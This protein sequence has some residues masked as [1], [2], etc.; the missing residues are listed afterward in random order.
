M[1][2]ICTGTAVGLRPASQR[3][4]LSAIAALPHSRLARHVAQVGT[5]LRHALGVTTVQLA[6]LAARCPHLTSLHVELHLDPSVE[7][8]G[9]IALPPRLKDLSLHLQLPKRESSPEE[10]EEQEE[11]EEEKDQAKEEGEDDEDAAEAADS[12][13]KTNAAANKAAEKAPPAEP[14]P[15]AML[16]RALANRLLESVSRLRQL[17]RLEIEKLPGRA[18]LTPLLALRNTLRHLTLSETSDWSSTQL[19]VFRSLPL[20]ETCDVEL[21]SQK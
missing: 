6:E 17:E 4:S 2:S 5:K 19:A 11:E 20:L 12:V 13:S 10:G 14:S 16:D 1:T 15:A 18:D 21:I 7:N 3:R 9:A 8:A